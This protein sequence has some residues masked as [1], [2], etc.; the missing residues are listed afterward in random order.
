MV[1]LLDFLDLV[2]DHINF[3]VGGIYQ[4]RQSTALQSVAHALQ[5]RNSVLNQFNDTLS[6]IA[7]DVYRILFNLYM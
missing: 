7:C 1:N 4:I 2:G 5:R 6:V 3:S